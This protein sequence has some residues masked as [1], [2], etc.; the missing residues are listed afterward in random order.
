MTGLNTTI[1]IPEPLKS[2]TEWL[3]YHHR[4]L[5][6]LT[7]VELLK[8]K[9]R[10]ENELAVSESGSTEERWL[11]DRLAKIELERQRRESK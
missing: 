3:R 7:I 9:I 1:Q 11:L 6:G 8:E 2:D 5:P 10:R 4:D